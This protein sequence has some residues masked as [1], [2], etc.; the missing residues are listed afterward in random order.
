MRKHTISYLDPLLGMCALFLSIQYEHEYRNGHE[1]RTWVCMY[2]EWIRVQRCQKIM[3]KNKFSGN[4][5][6]SFHIKF[7][8]VLDISAV[9]FPLMTLKINRKHLS[10]FTRYRWLLQGLSRSRDWAGWVGVEPSECWCHWA[11]PFILKIWFTWTKFP[12]RWLWKRVRL[13]FRLS[14]KRR[15]L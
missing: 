13:M 6:A 7:K 15:K 3:E 10:A 12:I 8:L 4:F 14:M 11:M 9:R 1:S 5:T 2:G